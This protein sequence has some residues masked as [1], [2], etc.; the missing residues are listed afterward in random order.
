MNGDNPLWYDRD[1]EVPIK[2]TS[3]RITRGARVTVV[4]TL[5]AAAYLA[6]WYLF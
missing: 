3:S 2:R 4:V 6:Y 5:L 1:E